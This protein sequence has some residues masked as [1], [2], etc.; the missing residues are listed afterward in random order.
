MLALHPEHLEAAYDFLRK[1]PPF[2][3]WKLPEAD[4]VHFRVAA[5]QDA[6]GEYILREGTHHIMISSC[7]CGHLDTLIQIMAH[8]M[9]HLAQEE[10]GHA[11]NSQHNSDFK[12]RAL[13]VSKLLGF[14]PRNF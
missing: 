8:E 2:K 10:S 14:D 5:R 6:H 1:L 12:R 4:A 11:N 7:H 9:V 3:G 13:R